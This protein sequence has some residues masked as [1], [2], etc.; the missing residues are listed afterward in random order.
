MFQWSA[1][2]F[3][4]FFHSLGSVGCADQP[5]GV[6]NGVWRGTNISVT[7]TCDS[8]YELVGVD[9]LNCINKKWEEVTQVCRK[10]K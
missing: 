7:L 5:P 10:S 9:T 3:W 6:A 2:H 8:G 4:I 1:A